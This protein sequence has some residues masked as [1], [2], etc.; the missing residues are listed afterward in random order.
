M[1]YTASLDL[2]EI[3]G[4]M[5]RHGPAGWNGK[6]P[7][8]RFPMRELVLGIGGMTMATQIHDDQ[9]MAL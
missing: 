8:G 3:R 6:A 2:N 7:T 9:S 4:I 5:N 1:K